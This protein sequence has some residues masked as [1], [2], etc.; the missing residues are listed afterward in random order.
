MIHPKLHPVLAALVR[1][2][3]KSQPMSLSKLM[4][5]VPDLKT[6]TVT[7]AVRNNYIENVAN[8]GRPARYAA[9]N[10]GRERYGIPLPG[11]SR[12]PGRLHI[13]TGPYDG[14]ELRPFTGRAGSQDAMALKS[15]GF[16]T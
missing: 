5:E 16:G 7:T 8:Q 3:D 14:A 10:E 15:F 6:S 2:L 9:T 12:A 1:R 4:I 11:L 13:S